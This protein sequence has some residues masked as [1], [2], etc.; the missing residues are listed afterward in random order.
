MIAYGIIVDWEPSTEYVQFDINNMEASPVVSITREWWPM[1]KKF[2][3]Y[4][5][6]SH[7]KYLGDGSFQLEI[8]YISSNN[9]HINVD[10]ARWGVSK[11]HI[12]PNSEYGEATW[13]DSDDSDYNGTVNWTIAGGLRKKPV[14]QTYTKL[15]RNQDMFRKALLECDKYCVLSGESTTDA[16]EAAHIIPSKNGGAEVIENGILLRADIH[17]LYDCGKFK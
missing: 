8:L 13:E 14:L 1:H 10:D 12:I 17:R 3:Q 2:V 6:T 9:T 4:N 15:Q 5:T 11:I 7:L 16:L